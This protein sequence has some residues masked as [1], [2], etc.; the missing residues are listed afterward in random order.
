MEVCFLMV[1][2][3]PFG[4]V[5]IVTLGPCS[6]NNRIVITLTQSQNNLCTQISVLLYILTFLIRFFLIQ[7]T[8]GLGRFHCNC[9]LR[10]SS[11]NCK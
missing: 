5:T 4:F 10:I 1:E 3:A 9:V 11:L 2:K 7:T 6:V 8:V